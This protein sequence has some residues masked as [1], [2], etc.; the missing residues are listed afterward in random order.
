[1]PYRITALAAVREIPA[2][3]AS[4]ERE[5][6]RIVHRGDG[7]TQPFHCC[8]SLSVPLATRDK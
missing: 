3:A 4:D 1:M 2:V 8:D 7:E 5:N 6:R